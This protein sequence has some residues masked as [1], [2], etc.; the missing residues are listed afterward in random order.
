M[1]QWPPL[2]TPLIQDFKIYNYK[3]TAAAWL[4]F[5]L[6][7]VILDVKKGSCINS[8]NLW[9]DSTGNRN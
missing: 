5:T 6:S 4:S 2:N 8:Y 9:F 1:A 7:F 3:P